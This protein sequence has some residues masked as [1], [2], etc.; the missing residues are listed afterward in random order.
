MASTRTRALDAAIELVG[1]GGLRALTHAR[2]DQRA[3]L[4]KGSTSNHFR[5]RA[6]LL[7]GAVDWI[8]LREASELDVPPAPDSAAGVIDALGRYL[9]YATTGAT[10]TLTAARLTLFME[11]NHNPALRE[12]VVRGRDVMRSWSVS[13]LARLGTPNP[14]VAA[15]AVMACCEGILLHRIA[16][17]D[18]TDPRPA[19]ALVVHSAVG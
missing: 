11:A 5:T 8:A 13:L 9:E 17:G 4:P 3:G 2:V 15:E 16:R 14:Q 6:A 19:L 10:R 7:S 1:T 18:D 12:A